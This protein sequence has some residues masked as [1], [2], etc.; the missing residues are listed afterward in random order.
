MTQ[1]LK[2]I[3]FMLPLFTGLLIAGPATAKDTYSLDLTNR[4]PGIA[5]ITFGASG[6]YRGMYAPPLGT[7][8]AQFEFHATPNHSVV[9][10]VGIL[11]M[12]IA[13]FVS[14]DL[15]YRYTF[16]HQ[17]HQPAFFL[18]GG[19]SGTHIFLPFTE[20]LDSLIGPRAVVGAKWPMNGNLVVESSVGLSYA[21]AEEFGG[22]MA[23]VNLRFG[24]RTK[25]QKRSAA[26]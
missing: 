10:S 26:R 2:R 24:W 21:F 6:Q 4:E 1:L 14:Y 17:A 22:P 25:R 19:L 20:L 13:N 12:L 7:V 15:G 5:T 23:E 16:N 18:E 8:D 11:P 9:T 3:A